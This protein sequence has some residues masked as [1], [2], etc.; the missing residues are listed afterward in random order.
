V[1]DPSSLH[2]HAD[3]D[4]LLQALLNVVTNSIRHAKEEIHV[5][6]RQK[7]NHVLISVQD[8]GEGIPEQILPTLFHRFVKG[9]G[10]ESGLG[11][12]IA[13][14]IVERCGGKITAK[15]QDAGGAMLDFDFPMCRA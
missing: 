10:G 2:I 15:N 12:A 14:A 4:K 3:Q 8:D 13:R 1:D 11:L 9:K 5:H 7:G 6:V